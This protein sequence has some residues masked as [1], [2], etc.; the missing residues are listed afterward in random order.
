MGDKPTLASD[1]F[2]FGV[3]LQEVPPSPQAPP[4]PH[5]PTHARVLGSCTSAPLR[6][7]GWPQE[8]LS[9]VQLRLQSFR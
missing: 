9:R 7:P 4:P 2:S 1:V 3:L 6:E 5:P 8:R